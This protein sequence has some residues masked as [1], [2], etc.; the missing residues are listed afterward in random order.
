MG[1]LSFILPA[2]ELDIITTRINKLVNK[3][4]LE[5]YDKQSKM[6]LTNKS[7]VLYYRGLQCVL[8]LMKP[9]SSIHIIYYPH[10]P[11]NYP[12]LCRPNIRAISFSR[13]GCQRSIAPLALS[14][15]C[16]LEQSVDKWKYCRE[17]R[18]KTFIKK[19]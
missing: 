4:Y 7:G 5:I 16:S 12:P 15:D 17:C 2:L 3:V 13:G 11:P 6:F 19:E 14:T 1:C 8:T 9:A 18:A 10:Y